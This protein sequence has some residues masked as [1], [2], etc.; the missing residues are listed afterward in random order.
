MRSVYFIILIFAFNIKDCEADFLKWFVDS[1]NTVKKAVNGF[2]EAVIGLIPS[3]KFSPAI[4]QNIIEFHLDLM[5]I[6]LKYTRDQLQL[7]ID[8]PRLMDCGPMI[9]VIRSRLGTKFSLDPCRKQLVEM[10][11]YCSN[12]KSCHNRIDMSRKALDKCDKN[13]CG[14]LK[15]VQ[16]NSPTSSSTCDF[17]ADVYCLAIAT[18][19]RNLTESKLQKYLERIG[20]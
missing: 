4:K 6:L 16:K 17:N 14:G 13:F 9:Y 5:D 1:W 20:K 18:H 10:S 11:K 3:S 8:D 19:K 2:K 7:L 12:Y 15:S